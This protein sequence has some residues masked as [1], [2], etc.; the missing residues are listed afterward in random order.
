LVLGRNSH[1]RHRF[2]LYQKVKRQYFL[3]VLRLGCSGG[4]VVRGRQVPRQVRALRVKL[5]QHPRSCV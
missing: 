1:F 3:V 5:S 2:T 4:P